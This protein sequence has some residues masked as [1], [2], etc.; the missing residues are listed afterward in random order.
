MVA[1]SARGNFYEPAPAPV[2]GGFAALRDYLARELA[3]LADVTHYGRSE[4][5]TLDIL[6][7]APARPIAGMVGYFAAG[8]VGAGEGLY[9]RKAGAWTKL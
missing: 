2:S 3:R 4:F 6:R 7:E 5:L 9:E 1:P 8:V